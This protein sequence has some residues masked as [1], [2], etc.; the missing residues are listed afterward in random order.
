MRHAATVL[1]PA[2]PGKRVALMV[3]PWPNDGA[4]I[5]L[6]RERERDFAGIEGGFD[7]GVGEQLSR[8]MARRE[9]NL[10]FFPDRVETIGGDGINYRNKRLASGQ[11]GVRLVD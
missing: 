7:F 8:R 4:P 2:W 11:T 10:H 3:R 1:S 5:N 9:G 6:A